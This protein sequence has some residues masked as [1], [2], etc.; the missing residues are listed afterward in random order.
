MSQPASKPLLWNTYEDFVLD[1]DYGLING[2]GPDCTI[3]PVDLTG[4]TAQLIVYN[5]DTPTTV[6]YR[7]QS[8]G[9][10]PAI[11]FPTPLTGSVHTVVPQATIEAFEV[12]SAAYLFILFPPSGSPNKVLLKSTVVI[13]QGPPLS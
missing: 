4:W 3:T 13:N 12:E 2:C 8:I 9:D 1:F 7:G 6:Y 5:P 11:T 10:S